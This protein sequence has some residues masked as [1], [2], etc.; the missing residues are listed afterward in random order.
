[1][2]GVSLSGFSDFWGVVRQVAARLV[3]L[4]LGALHIDNDG[5]QE[6][7]SMVAQSAARPER[8]QRRIARRVGERH[9]VARTLREAG[10]HAH[11]IGGIV[12]NS[13]SMPT[14]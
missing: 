12:V 7:A 5:K 4:R 1:M 6:D 11:R 10:D 8:H 2:L 9:R 14:T 3:M 13:E